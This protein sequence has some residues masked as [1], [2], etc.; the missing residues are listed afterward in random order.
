MIIIPIIW[1]SLR[2][3]PPIIFSPNSLS[4]RRISHM[5]K[6]EEKTAQ[7]GEVGDT[8]SCPFHG[9]KELNQTE[10]NH[11][12]F[13]RDRKEEVDVDETIR[14]EPTKGQEYSIDCSR[15]SN[16]GDKLIRSKDDRTDTRTDSTEEKVS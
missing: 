10:N 16:Y 15:S 11:H 12:I 6:A 4:D 9:G 7:M 13:S 2:P 1:P 14:E 5:E 8:P 3:L